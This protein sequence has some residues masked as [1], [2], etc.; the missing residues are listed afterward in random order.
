VSRSGWSCYDEFDYHK[1]KVLIAV[2]KRDFI[3]RKVGKL[4][5]P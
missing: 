1:L 3:T 2:L 5:V 4:A